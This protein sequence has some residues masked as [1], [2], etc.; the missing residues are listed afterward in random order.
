MYAGDFDIFF[1]FDDAT[2]DIKNNEYTI[3]ASLQTTTP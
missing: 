2:D 3:T 1:F